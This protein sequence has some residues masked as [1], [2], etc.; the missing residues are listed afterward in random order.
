MRNKTIKMQQGDNGPRHLR[1][2]A[3]GKGRPD[4][5]FSER[6][7]EEKGLGFNTDTYT[8]PQSQQ[9]LPS[10]LLDSGRPFQPRK[11]RVWGRQ[12]G[13]TEEPAPESSTTRLTHSDGECVA[14]TALVLDPQVRDQRREVRRLTVHTLTNTHSKNYSS[15][16]QP[17]AR[18]PPALTAHQVLRPNASQALAAAGV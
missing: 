6:A 12:R 11:S 4:T 7:R 1:E 15:F 13:I 5:T 3:W 9:R 14:K 17:I 2:W 8:Q 18:Q 10:P 16:F